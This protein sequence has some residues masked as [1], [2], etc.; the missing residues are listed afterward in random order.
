[1]LLGESPQLESSLLRK[2][3]GQQMMAGAALKG[4][5]MKRADVDSSQSQVCSSKAIIPLLKWHIPAS[6][7][8]KLT[9][10]VPKEF[11]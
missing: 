10:E 7:C 2:Q 3:E 6:C 4:I 1:V 11:S 9:E 8:K 5:P